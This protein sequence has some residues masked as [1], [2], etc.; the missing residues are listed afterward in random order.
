MPIATIVTGEPRYPE[1]IARRLGAQAPPRIAM[2]GESDILERAS[3][4]FCCSSTY[5]DGIVDAALDLAE[6]LSANAIPL[7]SGFQAPLERSM[8]DLFLGGG[9][10]AV[11]IP[12]QPLASLEIPPDWE[13]AAEAG[14]MLILSPFAS[15]DQR[16][17]ATLA[18]ARNR[19]VAALCRALLI[20]YAAPGGTIERLA[21]DL[22]H[23]PLP[24]LTFPDPANDLLVGLGAQAVAPEEIVTWW[25]VRFSGLL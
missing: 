8:L 2:L 7:V 15:D 3:L 20:A 24:L 13:E 10:P 17:P 19:F 16:A 1:I 22:H 18:K 12:A 9:A 25:Q 5:P 14:E 23:L 6:R 21:R 11:L 4:G